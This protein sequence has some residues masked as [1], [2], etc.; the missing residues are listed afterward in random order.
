MSN[1]KYRKGYVVITC[2]ED[3]Y[4]VANRKQ[5]VVLPERFSSQASAMCF[6]DRLI[7][8]QVTTTR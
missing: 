1:Y 6:I 7:E 3:D 2:G 4:R 5:G 8:Q